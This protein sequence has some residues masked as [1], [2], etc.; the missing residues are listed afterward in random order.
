MKLFISYAHVDTFQ[1]KDIVEIFKDA[2]HDPW[3]DHRL[4]PGQD[5]KAILAKAITDCEVFV[6]VLSPESIASE[7]CQW[8]FAEAVKLGKAI[9]PIRLQTNINPPDAISRYQWADFAEGPTRSAIARLLGGLHQAFVI[10]KPQA[11]PAPTN[12]TG[13]PAQA[14]LPTTTPPPP[15]PSS[16]TAQ[17]YFDRAMEKRKKYDLFGAIEDFTEAIR[18][19]PDFAQAYA[20]RGF[21]YSVLRKLDNA[22]HDYSEV[23][24][25]DPH[26]W[27]V[28]NSLARAYRDQGN[29]VMAQ[30]VERMKKERGGPAYPTDGMPPA[31]S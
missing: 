12:P 20:F 19:K 27:T 9:L 3:F 6:Y 8:E 1:V 14:A 11:P 26:Y 17:Q 25:I 28:Y 24:R 23:I 2:G 13:T 7:W 18:L 21:D 4:L 30:F 16:M 15:A 31:R 10:P 22:I 5:W 29:E